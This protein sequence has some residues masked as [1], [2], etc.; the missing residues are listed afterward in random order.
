MALKMNSYDA[1]DDCTNSEIVQNLTWFDFRSSHGNSNHSTVPC[2][3]GE[4]LTEGKY[5]KLK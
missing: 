1:S 3:E 4:T 5:E 2:K